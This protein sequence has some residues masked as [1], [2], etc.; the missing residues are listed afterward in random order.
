MTHQDWIHTSQNPRSH[1]FW[2]PSKWPLDSGLIYQGQWK[3]DGRS[4]P[5]GHEP[6]GNLSIG[7]A[8]GHVISKALS[9][10]RCG[11][12]SSWQQLV[13]LQNK[14]LHW[15]P[16]RRPKTPVDPAVRLENRAVFTWRKSQ[17]AA[18]QERPNTFRLPFSK[19]E[20]PLQRFLEKARSSHRF[21]QTLQC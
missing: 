11:L 15:G 16:A 10:A 17:I 7:P 14:S 8:Y 1:D 3:R 4:W 12:C 20:R 13:R 18:R 5:H 9:R 6:L 2:H 21:W 19:E